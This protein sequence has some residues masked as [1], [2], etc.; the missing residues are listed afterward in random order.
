MPVELMQ[1]DRVIAC[2]CGSL[3]EGNVL[4]WVYFYKLGRVLFDSG[5]PNMSRKVVEA[6]KPIEAILITHHHEDHVGAASL[7][8]NR[9]EVYAP[10]RSLDLLLN[11][12]DIPFYRE[13]VWGN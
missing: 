8:Q 11:P 13:L 12:P 4:A 5:C 10:E 3:V 9:V 6:I 2:R 7:L 1:R